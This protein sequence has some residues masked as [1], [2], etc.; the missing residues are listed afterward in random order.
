MQQ[1]IRVAEQPLRLDDLR[2]FAQCR[3]E[4]RDRLAGDFAQRDEHQRGKVQPQGAWCQA[5]VVT[6]D[7]SRFFQCL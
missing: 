2:Y 7:G 6:E 4:I 3:L 5:S 1:V